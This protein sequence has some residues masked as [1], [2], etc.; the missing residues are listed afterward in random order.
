MEQR[1]TPTLPQAV[2]LLPKGSGRLLQDKSLEKEVTDLWPSVT[3]KEFA[4][5]SQAG[6]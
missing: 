6:T 3:Q 5:T 1:D 2:A 4:W